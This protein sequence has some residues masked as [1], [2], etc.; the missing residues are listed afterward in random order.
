[1]LGLS[2]FRLLAVSDAYDEL[3]QAVETTAATAWCAGCG[4]QAVPH[5]RRQVR[6][7]D[8]PSSGRAVTL[9]WLKRLWRC[10]APARLLRTWSEASEELRP[11][12]SLSERARRDACRRVGKDGQDVQTVAS[13]LGVGWAT[14]MRAVRDYGTP[15]VDDPARLAGDVAVGVDVLAVLAD[16]SAGITPGPLGQR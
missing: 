13:S 12:S 14:V 2:G 9:L 11:R 16:L 1:M 7:R 8:L 15:L 6:V 10:P 4:V 5:G 3:E